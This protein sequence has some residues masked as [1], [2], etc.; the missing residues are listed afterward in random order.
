MVEGVTASGFPFAY[1]EQIMNDF[2]IVDAIADIVSEEPSRLL[3]GLSTFIS[4]VMGSEGKKSLYDHVRTP[5][6]RVP[7]DKIQV[8]ITEMLT[9]GREPVKK[10]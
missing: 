10:S 6:G 5:D 2:E 1:D 4:K 7:I 9:A 8:E 3:T